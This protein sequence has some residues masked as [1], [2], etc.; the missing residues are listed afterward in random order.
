MQAM[1][2]SFSYYNR[3]AYFAP[4]SYVRE[5]TIDPQLDAIFQVTTPG[6]PALIG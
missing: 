4:S 1:L 2:G 6:W 5:S 3:P